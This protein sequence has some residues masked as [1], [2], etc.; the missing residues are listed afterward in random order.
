MGIKEW[1]KRQLV[2]IS[3]AT[4]KVSDNLT[5]Q[6]GETL[7]KSHD[8]VTEKDYGTLLYALKHKEVNQEVRNLRWRTY[9]VLNASQNLKLTLNSTDL[10]G[11]SHYN[12]INGVEDRILLSKV[13]LDSF[14]NYKLEMV[15]NNSE[16]TMDSADSMGNKNLTLYD[17]IKKATNENGDEVASHGEIN[18][19]EYFASVKGDRPIKIKRDSIPRFFIENFTKKLNILRINDEERLLEFYVSKYPEELKPTSRLFI[20]KMST[21]LGHGFVGMDM[22]DI[23]EVEFITHNTLGSKNFLSYSYEI[24]KVNKIVEFDGNYVIKFNAKVIN[25]GID[26]LSDFIEKDLDKRYENKEVKKLKL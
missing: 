13:K 3:I 1:F 19:N 5:S 8:K 26:I 7:E 9:K 21:A 22:F 4:S 24:L 16:I 6:K 12:A 18:A 17:E 14:D 11:D 20:K 10:D 23:K 25:N 15:V 2:A